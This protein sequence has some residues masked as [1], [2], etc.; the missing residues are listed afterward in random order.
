M[1]QAASPDL[2]AC[3]NY[4]IVEPLPVLQEIQKSRLNSWPVQWFDSLEALPEFEGVHFSNELVDAFPF[5]L[6]CSNGSEWKEMR[7]VQ[8]EDGFVFSESQ[9]SD[10]LAAM[11]GQ[12]PMRPAGYLTEVRP[13]ANAWIGQVA[14]RLKRGFL[15]VL[16]YGLSREQLL[17]EDRVR[18]TFAS[19]QSHRR[20][21]NVL[22][23]PGQKDITAHVDFTALAE[24][25]QA[26]GLEACGFCDQHH[27]LVGAATSLLKRLDGQLPNATNAKFF[28][29]LKA[30]MHPETMGTQ[31]FAFCLTAGLP[32]PVSLSA[33]R[34]GAKGFEK[35]LT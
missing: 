19:F 31:F 14:A 29:A 30:L 21:D 22:A 2:L 35:I 32:T 12:F 15:L 7:V 27:F 26:G 8:G 1:F 34:D 25:G 33:F 4:V 9:I 16:D 10:Q 28:Q 3:L 5:H 6:L 24:A 13:A 17:R 23:D 18:G 20:D 11:I